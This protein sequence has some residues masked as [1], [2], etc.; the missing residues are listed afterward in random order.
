MEGSK[1]IPGAVIIGDHVQALGIARSLGRKKIPVYLVN[2]RAACIGRFSRYV[3]KFLVCPS[4]KEDSKLASFLANLAEKEGLQGWILL[5][6]ND[7]AVYAVSKNREKLKKYFLVPTPD[8]EITKLAYNKILTYALAEKNGI[9]IPKTVYPKDLGELSEAV[10]GMSF[11]IIIKPAVMHT[12][13]EK[14]KL[15][16]IL[17]GNLE[18]L[19]SAYEKASKVIDP[20][21]IMV[22][23]VIPGRPGKL[24][25]FCSFF[26]EGKVKGMIVGRRVRQRP[27]DFG[28][29][30]TFAQSEKV[31]SL[32]AYG[33]RLLT[34]MD[35][36]GLSE[37][38]FKLDERDGVYKLL[39]IN[40]RT[41]LWHSLAGR[42]GVDMPYMLYN[43]L[44]NGNAAAA[45]DYRAGVK[46]LHFYT[47]L[48]V[49]A[50]EILKG[51]MKL[52]DYLRSLSGEK[53]YAVMAW[54]D[55][56]PFIA[57]TLLLPYLKMVR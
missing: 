35:Y 37:V 38:E 36:Y 32:V 53:E 16:A 56:L 39:E 44:V 13:Y 28:R 47:D 51:N 26:K 14:T 40:P 42:C 12:F 23:E 19:K 46:W 20:S 54:D 24:Y 55:P 22:Q 15:K 25:S 17:A 48:S 33:T 45:G 4:L 5:P 2:P 6:N 34:A 49:S 27:M 52:T 43:D 31:P 1:K 3:K 10:S 41:W 8:W 9:P 29:G 18:E 57:E 11:P 50:G 21:E 30:T 7:A